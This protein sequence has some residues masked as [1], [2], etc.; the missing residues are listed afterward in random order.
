ME[1]KID[2]GTGYMYSYN[3]NHPCSNGSGKV[4]EHVYSF[5][6][7]TGIIPNSDECIH[8]IDRDK[9]NNEFSN[10][11]LMTKSDHA[12]LH[13]IE[14]RQRAVVYKLEC[15][16]CGDVFESNKEKSKFCSLDCSSFYSRKF[17]VSK[18]ELEYLVWK[19]PM[20]KIGKIF[21]VSDV[22]VSKRCKKLGVGKPEIGYWLRG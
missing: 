8:H 18:D 11:R 14:D 19:M 15:K 9:T 20:T 5:W 22:A 3:P 6:V 16:S 10:L 1:F 12:K 7:E 2:K 21:G 17:D 13:Q 4:M